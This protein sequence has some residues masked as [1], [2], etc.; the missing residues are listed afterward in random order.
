MSKK[1]LLWLLLLALTI[2]GIIVGIMLSSNEKTEE[3][4]I[5][6]NDIRKELCGINIDSMKVDSGVVRR[7]ETLS[8]ILEQYN[9]SR[10]EIYE[11]TKASK[12]VFDV[13]DLK[14]GQPYM[15]LT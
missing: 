2:S 6:L 10:S 12:G 9:L 8:T 13:K 14:V 15:I 5:I 11:L 1:K 3:E 4:D 7:G